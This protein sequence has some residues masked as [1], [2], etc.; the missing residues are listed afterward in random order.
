MRPWRA[1]AAALV[2]LFFL[3]LSAG[4]FGRILETVRGNVARG[5][6]ISDRIGST[7]STLRQ[8]D[9]AALEAQIADLQTKLAAGTATPA[10]VSQLQGLLERV[11]AVTGRAG[12]QG[13]AGPSG[14]PGPPGATSPAQPDG[15]STTS[16]TAGGTTST[17]RP[18]TATTTTTRPRNTTTTT[19]CVVGV[20]R[21]LK[22]GC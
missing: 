20:G 14:P 16:T 6:E 19:R 5:I 11:R 13:P 15:T 2:I 21:L 18:P 9:T 17:T 3:G 10:Q 4:Q 1:K 22:V 12:T 7:V 8:V